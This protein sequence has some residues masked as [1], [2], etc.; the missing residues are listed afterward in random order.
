MLQ[1]IVAMA[2]VACGACSNAATP[3]RKA[4]IGHATL[5]NKLGHDVVAGPNIK[6]AK[7]LRGLSSLNN[8]L[9]DDA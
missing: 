4:V 9:G 6:T 8:E 5:T 2:V 3:V 7:E 1:S